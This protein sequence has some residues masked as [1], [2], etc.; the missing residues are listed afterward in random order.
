MPRIPCSDLKILAVDE[1]FATVMV[2]LNFYFMNLCCCILIKVDVDQIL[3][4]LK[5]PVLECIS[6]LSLL[7][8]F[9]KLR[10]DYRLQ[11]WP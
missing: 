4:V 9:I 6:L 11:G 5:N 2:T 3:D 10:D 7:G 1:K 8:P